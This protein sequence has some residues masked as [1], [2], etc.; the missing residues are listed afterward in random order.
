MVVQNLLALLIAALLS[1]GLRFFG[2]IQTVLFIPVTMSIV[3]VGYIWTLI[4]NPNWGALN[5]LL[6]GIGLYSWAIAWLGS[7][8]TALFAVSIVNAWQFIGLAIM[9]FVAGFQNIPD[10]LYEAADMDGASGYKKFIHISVPQLVPVIG[11]V[12]IL[13]LVGNFS[14]FE[15][16]YAMEGT[17][18]G[19]NYA[20]DV[21]GTYFYRTAFSSLSGMIP[22]PGL[23]AA[24]STVTFIIVFCL[25]CIWLYFTQWRTEK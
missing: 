13:T 16:I 22:D 20:T 23:G 18:A 12:T 17:L 19:P 6:D 4:L 14:A 8:K 24:I 3:L 5:K 10:D 2:W 7:E 9:L 15:L 21:L 1:K 25:V 11:I